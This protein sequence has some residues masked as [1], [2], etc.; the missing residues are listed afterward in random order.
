M[1]P[2]SNSVGDLPFGDVALG[3]HSIRGPYDD[4]LSRKH[5]KKQGIRAVFVLL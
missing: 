4:H 5:G 3:V 1:R 2:Q